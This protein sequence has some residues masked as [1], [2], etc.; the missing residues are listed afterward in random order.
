MQREK[1]TNRT[2]VQLGKAHGF[3]HG[4]FKKTGLDATTGWAI[5]YTVSDLVEQTA[6]SQ[7]W[8]M[9][10]E[11]FFEVVKMHEHE[12]EA[13]CTTRL[14]CTHVETLIKVPLY[15]LLLNRQ[16]THDDVERR[17]R[18]RANRWKK[19]KETPDINIRLNI[20]IR[21]RFVFVTTLGPK[22]CCFPSVAC[23]LFFFFSEGNLLTGLENE[24]AGN[25]YTGR[26]IKD[27]IKKEKRWA[28]S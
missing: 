14:W 9:K 26:N 2:L 7:L 20:S 25:H 18:K 22:R 16:Q 5:S 6:S 12:Y 19:K 3:L 13:T 10:L 27:F 8:K 23:G 28:D 4:W 21:Q 17:S 1:K 15:T 11:R 24:E